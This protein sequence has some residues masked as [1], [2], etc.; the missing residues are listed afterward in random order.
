LI[1]T[2][3]GINP[4]VHTRY[5]PNQQ[6]RYLG[7][8]SLERSFG[9]IFQ[10]VIASLSLVYRDACDWKKTCVPLLLPIARAIP[11][12]VEGEYCSGI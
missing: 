5:Q 4:L 10:E 2:E 7:E 9:E 1:T 6:G 3:P 11:S 8:V 12:E